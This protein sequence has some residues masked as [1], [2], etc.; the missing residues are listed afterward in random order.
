MTDFTPP[1]DDLSPARRLADAADGLTVLLGQSTFT[2]E[3][4]QLRMLA[5]AL[6][7][8]LR[9]AA[10]DP[11]LLLYGSAH[12]MAGLVLDLADSVNTALEQSPVGSLAW[13]S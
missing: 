1:V 7:P 2:A 4:A 8:V 6:V 11:E 5:S 13:A 12:G 10:A 3:S 9:E